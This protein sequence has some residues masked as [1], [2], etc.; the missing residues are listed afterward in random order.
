[1]CQRRLLRERLT[2]KQ[3]NVKADSKRQLLQYR[4]LAIGRQI[5]NT[6]V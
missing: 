2:Y 4:L 3:L 5:H 6:A 1:M